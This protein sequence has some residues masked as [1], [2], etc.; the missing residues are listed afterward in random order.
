[1][2]RPVFTLVCALA[3]TSSFAQ[4]KVPV[5]SLSADSAAYARTEEQLANAM[6]NPRFTFRIDS[7]TGA[8]MRLREKAVRY[9]TVYRPSHLYTRYEDRPADLSSVTRL[10]LVNY[11][12]KSLPDSLFLMNNLR[13]L[14]FINTRI[15]VLPSRLGSLPSLVKVSFMNNRPRGRLKLRKNSKITSLAIHDDELDLRPRNYR[16]LS[17]LQSLDLSRNNMSR[18]PSLRGTPKLTRLVLTENQ[19]TLTDLRK[20][21]PRLEELVLT[22]NKVSQVPPALGRFT[23]LKKINLNANQV[24]SLPKEIGALQN[25]EQ[26]SLYK[27]NLAKLPPEIYTLRNLRVIDLYYNQIDQLDPAIRN[28]SKLEIL[29]AAN[30]RLYTL[31]E[32]LGELTSLRELY[33]HH[34]RISSLPASTANLDSLRVLR[35]NDNLILEFPPVLTRLHALENLDVASN[36]LTALPQDLFDLPRLRILSLKGNPFEE[37]ARGRIMEWSRNAMTQRGVMIHLEGLAEISA[38]VA[39]P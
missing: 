12:G 27:N 17:A 14:E 22:T 2:Q 33:L 25:L 29:Y 6:R 35:I 21:M 16:K 13:E 36:Q 39:R 9:R 23:G 15:G 8:L 19:L 32:E 38:D 34:N 20:G 18:F 11:K 31:P 10:S 24:E 4:Q 37:A 7:L 30:N 26:L 28:W 3:L 1:M 5:F